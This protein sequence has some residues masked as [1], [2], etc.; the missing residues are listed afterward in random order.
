[1][2]WVKIAYSQTNDI[3][4][5]HHKWPS[6]TVNDPNTRDSSRLKD[7]GKDRLPRCVARVSFSY[8]RRS[9]SR[10]AQIQQ[11]RCTKRA[12]RVSSGL[13]RKVPRQPVF[14]VSLVIPILTCV[15][16]ISCI[17]KT[18]KYEFLLPFFLMCITMLRK[19]SFVDIYE[20]LYICEF[21]YY[22]P[23]IV[24]DLKD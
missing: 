21:I 1:M 23:I 19:N 4:D 5:P 2:L 3:K 9:E 24:M 15:L 8:F 10:D 11:C 16:W 12:S 20:C 13:R 7:R 22:S 14:F 6:F 18:Y 17:S